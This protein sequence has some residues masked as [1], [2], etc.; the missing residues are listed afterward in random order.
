MNPV[1]PLIHLVDDDDAVRDALALLVGSVGLRVAAWKHP[2]DFLDRFEKFEL[3]P[4][5]KVRHL[6]GFA[7]RTLAALPIRCA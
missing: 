5:T 3:V 1:S 2:Q 4:G 6:P 7:L